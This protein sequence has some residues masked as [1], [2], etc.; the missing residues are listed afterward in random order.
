MKLGYYKQ[1]DGVRAIAALMVMLFHFFAPLKGGGGVLEVL[2]KYSVFG[3]TGVSLFFVLSGF[4]ITRILLV[5]KESPDYFVDFYV[6]RSLRIF[7]LYYFFLILYFFIIPFLLHTPVVPFGQQVYFWVYLQNFAITFRWP[8]VGPSHFWSLAVEEHFY[9]L[10]P[11]LVY[12]LSKKGIKIA[13]AAMLVISFGCRLLLLHEKYEVFYFTFTRMDE[14]V[15]GA[16]LAVWESDGKLKNSSKKFLLALS[17]TVVPTIFFWLR[18]TGKAIPVVQA[19]KFNLLGFLYF[20]MIGL[21]ISLSANSAINK[22]LSG[23]VLSLTGKISYGLYVY[24]PLCFFLVATFWPGIPLSLRLIADIA[25]TFLVAYLSY[26]LFE[27]RF[28]KL[29]N[30]F[31]YDRSAA[32]RKAEGQH[33]EAIHESPSLPG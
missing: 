6:R 33:I 24:H 1:L 29:K 12:F 15:I 11:C 23:K 5:T 26:N 18:V 4:L 13:V 3:Q 27:V 14:I 22:I 25:S 2:Q 21:V 7:P 16:L 31:S 19:I 9:L 28:I 10:W 8:A 30:R 32:K 17:L 20:C